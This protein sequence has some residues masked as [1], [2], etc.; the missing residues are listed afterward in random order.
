MEKNVYDKYGAS[1]MKLTCALNTNEL[2]TRSHH[3]FKSKYN[4]C[5]LLH[6]LGEKNELG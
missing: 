2:T 5:S 4:S 3:L 1:F 6:N